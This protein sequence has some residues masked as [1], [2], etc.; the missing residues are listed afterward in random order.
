MG[1]AF[2]TLWWRELTLYRR[3][4][5]SEGLLNLLLPLFFFL[6]FGLGFQTV[7][8]PV[9]GQS[10]M[11]FLIPGVTLLSIA[12]TAFDSTAWFYATNRRNHQWQ[13]V[14]L[15]GAFLNKRALLN[16]Q[17]AVATIK[18]LIHGMILLMIM[19]FLTD[20][21][22]IHLNLQ[23]FIVFVILT[24][25]QFAALGHLAGIYLTPGP[26][27]GRLTVFVLFPLFLISGLGWSITNYS[28]FFEKIVS[29]L[30]TFALIDGVQSAFLRGRIENLFLIVSVIETLILLGLTQ[31]LT[32]TQE[33]A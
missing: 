31:F 9:T 17:I 22:N 20:V 7:L 10:Y 29:W 19:I 27:L 5:V 24:A 14:I 25:I 15:M 2:K 1:N 33:S 4:F 11:V 23:S 6:F 12:I 21:S 13:E 16:A 26:L 8:K 3:N 32:G 18:S 28:P 30:P